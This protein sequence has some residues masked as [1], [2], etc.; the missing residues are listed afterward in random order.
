[1][2]YV[3]KK[4]GK[5]AASGDDDDEMDGEAKKK[6]NEPK[7][8]YKDLKVGNIFSGTSYYKATKIAPDRVETRCESKDITVSRDIIEC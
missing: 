8:D 7:W 3:L 1:M 2:K 5:K 4:G 6:S